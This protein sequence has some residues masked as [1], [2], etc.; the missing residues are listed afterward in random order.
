MK[1]QF[2]TLTSLLTISGTAMMLTGCSWFCCESSCDPCAPC[3]P[4]CCPKPT[5]TCCPQPHYCECQPWDY[6]TP[7]Y[8]YYF[9]PS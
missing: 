7:G 8:Y 3:E 6:C 5:P 9:D 2:K 4:V 1:E